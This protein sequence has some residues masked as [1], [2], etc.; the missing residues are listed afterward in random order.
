MKKIKN[1]IENI[2]YEKF[3]FP[4]FLLN[5]K[6]IWEEKRIL[7]RLI[8]EDEKFILYY[9]IGEK[10]IKF[11]KTTNSPLVQTNINIQKLI[12]S[13]VYS[14]LPKFLRDFKL[15]AEIVAPQNFVDFVYNSFTE[16]IPYYKFTRKEHQLIYSI[17]L[18]ETNI[19][20]KNSI[21]LVIHNEG[22]KNKWID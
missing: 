9:V 5:T 21:A 13:H 16:I 11:E 18:S 2:Y 4:K 10:F 19:F 6:K 22:V 17:V 12:D 7:M 20:L 3:I 8:V 1:Y 14:D 15:N